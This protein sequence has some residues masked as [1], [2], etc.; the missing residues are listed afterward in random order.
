MSLMGLLIEGAMLCDGD[1]LPH[2]DEND[3]FVR[4]AVRGQSL[5]R[6]GV[7]AK[8][9]KLLNLLA[10]SHRFEDLVRKTGWDSDEVRRVLHALMLGNLVEQREPDSSTQILVFDTDKERAAQC[11]QFFASDQSSFSGKAVGDGLALQ[12]ALKRMDPDIIIFDVSD[13]DAIHAIRHL[14]QTRGANLKCK[15]I[16]TS[17][18]SDA[19]EEPEQTDC[20]G[21]ELDMTIE[22]PESAQKLFE[23][24]EHK[25]KTRDTPTACL[26]A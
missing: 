3:A 11:R 2:I 9:I 19:T 26:T 22:R 4:C 14:R 18:R 24:L 21:F 13:P 23:L 15:W 20:L 7:S 1:G 6:A 17:P 10:E 25:E 8:H 5:D 16:G 12:L